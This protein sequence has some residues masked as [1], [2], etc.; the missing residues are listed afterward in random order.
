MK[1]SMCTSSALVVSHITKAKIGR[2]LHK[3]LRKDGHI[4]ASI[5]SSQSEG[6]DMNVKKQ[7]VTEECTQVPRRCTRK[8]RSAG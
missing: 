7:R 4:W 5:A 8:M 2:H 3:N 1:T 6:A